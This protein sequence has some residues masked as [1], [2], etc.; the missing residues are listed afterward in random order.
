MK[1]PNLRLSAAVALCACV[2]AAPVAAEIDKLATYARMRAIA[3]DQQSIRGVDSA[4]GRYVELQSEFNTLKASMGGDDPTLM[5]EGTQSRSGIAPKFAK[6]VPTPPSGMVVS[7]STFTQSTP[8]AVPTGPA[9][10][11]STVLVSGTG[12]YTWDIDLTT[13]LTHTFAADL[14]ITITSPAGTVVTLT[15]DNGAGNDNVFNGTLWDDDANPAGQVPYTTNNGMVTD[16]AYVNLTTATPLVPEEA[17]GAFV[18]EDPNGTWTITVSDD[19]A[20]DGGSLDAFSIAVSTLPIAPVPTV[21][22]TVTQATPTAIPTGP[23]VVTS[24]VLVAGAGV[25]LTDLNLTTAITHTFAADLDIT[26]MSPAGTIVTLST[27]NGAGNDNTFNGTVW[28]DDANPGGQVPYTTN[29]GVTTDHAYV[30]VTTATPLVIEEAMAAFIGENPNGTWTITISDDLSGDGGSLD[31]W[32]LDITTGVGGCLSVTCPANVTVSND[33][34]QCGAVVN[35]PAPTADAACGVVTCSPASG[36]FFPAGTSTMTNCSTAVGGRSCAFTVTVNDTQPPTITCPANILAAATS[37]AGSVV[38][39]AAP[40]AT[41]NCPGSTVACNPASGATFPIATTSDSCT[42]TDGAS[43]T[44]TCGFNVA[45][46]SPDVTLTKSTPTTGTIAVGQQ[47]SFTLTATNTN[48]QVAA[49]NAVVTDT[50]PAGLAYVS[51][52]CGAS[53]AAPTLTWTIPSLAASSSLSCLLTTTVAAPGA[54]SNTAQVTTTGTFDNNSANDASTTGLSAFVPPP[55]PFAGWSAMLIIVAVL[56]LAR[57]RT[58]Q[59]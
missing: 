36:S 46:V 56:V 20:G 1:L 6:V 8:T 12:P 17:L 57:R 42:N 3:A 2:L 10:V 59:R 18:G 26:L 22:P 45:V 25:T 4:H 37:S 55:I 14:D 43:N 30:N 29:N 11:T 58:A 5:Y 19:L 21:L 35:Y 40:V 39:F 15:T 50:L 47:V 31:S 7:T 49:T 44:A 33:V 54:I 24:T 52:D 23:A 28:D 51:N 41:D 48:A 32:S 27:D 53:F 9:A 34:N 38:T 16:Q 13:N